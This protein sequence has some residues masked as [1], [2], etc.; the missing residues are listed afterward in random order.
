[1]SSF[2]THSHEINAVGNNDPFRQTEESDINF[3]S[4]FDFKQISELTKHNGDQIK[5]LAE[6]LLS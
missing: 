6:Q 2:Q 3:G 1:M 4:E 5:S